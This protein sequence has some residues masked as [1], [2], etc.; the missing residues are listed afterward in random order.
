M[1]LCAAYP[2]QYVAH[3]GTPPQID[4]DPNKDVWKHVS[5]SEPFVE[6]R[7]QDAPEGTGPSET[8]STRMKMVWDDE[9]LYVLAVMH[10]AEGDEL[11]AKF[12]ERNS[13][14]FH[15]D[16]DFEIF[17]DPA[18]C[19][20]GYKE[21][22]LNA[23]NT[24]W[25]LLLTR[26]YMDGGNEHSGRVAKPEQ[27]CYWEVSS[28]K[29]A[30]RVLT[31]TLNDPSQP[32]TWCCE[33]ALAHSDSLP[34]APVCGP[35]PAVGASWRI[36]FSRVEDCGKVNWVWAPQV[37]WDPAQKRYEGKVN[38][39]LPDAWGYVVF[40]DAKGLLADGEP[41]EAW[42]DPAWPARS[43]AAAAYY[44]AR[45]FREKSGGVPPTSQELRDDEWFTAHT[46]FD[47]AVVKSEG[48]PAEA[49]TVELS[50]HGYLAR[51]THTRLLT[52]EPL[53]SSKA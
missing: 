10:L 49:Y 19:C 30:A 34:N 44:S 39:H 1:A 9:F 12:T 3:R 6:I 24:V 8:Q 52:V 32:S 37:I 17:L 14:I 29:T 53:P 31:G 21:L 46:S 47:V 26:P 23:I 5:W 40:A 51:I 45:S 20:H 36:N 33:V 38:M 15:T 35:T 13:P 22:E 28:Q 41:A 7:G 50:G 43:A 4:A 16:S 48:E 42:R 2:R 25:N 27:P 11:I 18:G